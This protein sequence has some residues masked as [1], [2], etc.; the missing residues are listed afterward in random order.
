MCDLVVECVDFLLVVE[1][2]G[3]DEEVVCVCFE[4]DV[5]WLFELVCV[6]VV[7]DECYV[8]D[9]DVEVLYCC[10]CCKIECVECWFV[11][12]IDVVFVCMVELCMLVVVVVCWV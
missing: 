4:Y 8:V 9:C 3:V 11:C 1:V 7:V 5:E 6:Y 12:G 2:F 10:V